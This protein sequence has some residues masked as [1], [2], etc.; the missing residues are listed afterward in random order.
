[1]TSVFEI[2]TIYNGNSIIPYHNKGILFANDFTYKY[3]EPTSTWNQEQCN[4]PLS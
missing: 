1:M 2:K 3:V 4:I